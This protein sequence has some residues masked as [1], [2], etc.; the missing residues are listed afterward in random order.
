MEY[1]EIAKLCSESSIVAWHQ[2]FAAKKMRSARF[3]D[4]ALRI[5][6]F[7]FL[8]ICVLLSDMYPSLFRAFVLLQTTLLLHMLILFLMYS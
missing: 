7:L 6:V 8:K 3:Y 2:A 5:V 1:E 4:I